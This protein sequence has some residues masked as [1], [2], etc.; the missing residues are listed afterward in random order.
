LNLFLISFFHA[1]EISRVDAEAVERSEGGEF[2]FANEKSV[3][4]SIYKF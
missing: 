1:D 2:V 4:I 3:L